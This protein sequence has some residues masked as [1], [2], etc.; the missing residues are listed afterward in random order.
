[1]K[2]KFFRCVTEEGRVMMDVGRATCAT[3]GMT[4]E[5]PPFHFDDIVSAMKSCAIPP[6]SYRD[7][8]GFLVL[9]CF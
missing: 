7:Y 6:A 3:L 1:M 2:G 9:R 5:N 4:W 8:A